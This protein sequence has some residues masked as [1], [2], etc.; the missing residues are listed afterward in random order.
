MNRST[1]T[2]VILPILRKKAVALWAIST[3]DGPMG[4]WTEMLNKKYPDG[5]TPLFAVYRKVLACKVC[6]RRGIQDSCTHKRGK[7]PPW[8][9]SSA[10][11]QLRA[12]AGGD[13][14]TFAREMLNSD[15]AGNT[16][17]WF[18]GD[19]LRDLQNFNRHKVRIDEDVKWFSVGIDPA[20]GG[21]SRYCIVS[22]VEING[23]VVVSLFF[24]FF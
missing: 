13:A 10:S 23:K 9:S 8:L 19:I 11:E 1:I 15:M 12:L 18:N 17:P 14:E 5:K 22:S 4:Y 21:S 7:L 24:F 16:R 2:K 3:S 20:L 6:I